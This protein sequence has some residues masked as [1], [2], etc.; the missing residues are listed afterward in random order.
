[1]KS[2]YK[3]FISWLSEILN[4]FYNKW[5]KGLKPA[6]W[7][8][9]VGP[10]FFTSCFPQY[11]KVHTIKPVAADS[12]QHLVN[13][14]KYFILRT[15][16]EDFKL[17]GIN[18]SSDQLNAKADSLPVEYLKF[19]KANNQKAHRYPAKDKELVM[20]TVLLYTSDSVKYDDRISLSMNNLYQMDTYQFNQSKTTLTHVGV[21][22]GIAAGTAV[23]IFVIAYIA[24]GPWYPN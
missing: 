20:N 2:T 18:I 14:N 9:I 12:I 24:S 5:W 21:I 15:N 16:Q 7:I 17:T 19:F 13:Q 10:V 3:Y 1:M 6:Y 11:Y 23:A 22:A 8:M 4:P